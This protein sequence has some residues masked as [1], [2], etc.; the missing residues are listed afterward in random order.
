MEKNMKGRAYVIILNYNGWQDTL[1]CIDSVLKSDYP[2]FE[3]VVCDNASNNESVSK[4]NSWIKEK[5]VADRVKLISI[6]KNRGFSAGNNRGIKYA[7]AQGDCE[8][9]WILNND[10]VVDK[11]ALS[12]MI[13][14]SQNSNCDGVGSCLLNYNRPEIL[15]GVGGRMDLEN[16][17][18]YEIEHEVNIKDLK[19]GLRIDILPGASFLITRKVIDKTGL[20]DEDYFLYCE[21]LELAH[22]IRKMGMELC[23][24]T[25]S[26]TFHKGGQSTGKYGSSFRDYHLTR[27]WTLFVFK[28]YPEHYDNLHKLNRKIIKKRL[29]HFHIKRAWAVY[30]GERDARK[31][32]GR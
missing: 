19:E 2:S 5:N 28:H 3:I 13:D 31:L 8:Y 24:A 23:Y 15:Q 18:T 26:Y 25:D 9:L 12:K 27:S 6:E 32:L 1:E 11:S 30:S 7:I 17:D 16:F 21:E 10:T 14:K 4:I 22:R 29:K 20:F